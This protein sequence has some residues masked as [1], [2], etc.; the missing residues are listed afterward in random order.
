MLHSSFEFL[1]LKKQS[2]AKHTGFVSDVNSASAMDASALGHIS[3]V[4]ADMEIF[5]STGI[6][7]RVHRFLHTLNHF[8]PLRNSL[9]C[10]QCGLN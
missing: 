2:A 3:E 9:C 5:P 7:W 10:V 1:S 4:N 6:T 8:Y